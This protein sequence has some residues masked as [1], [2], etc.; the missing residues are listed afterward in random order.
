MTTL[1][2]LKIVDDE[3]RHFGS[4]ESVD[5]DE[6]G[7]VISLDAHEGGVLGVGSETKRTDVA[8]IRTLGAEL[9]TIN[10]V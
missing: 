2:D 9:L 5:V 4:V 8:T 3:G 1:R 10:S 6:Q 7:H